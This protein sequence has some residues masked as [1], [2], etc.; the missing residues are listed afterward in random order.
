MRKLF[1]Y[2]KEF[3]INDFVLLKYLSVALFLASCIALNYHFDFEDSIIDSYDGR[4][5]HF[6]FYF[7]FYAFAY[8]GTVAIISFFSTKSFLKEREF[9]IKSLFIIAVIALDASFYFHKYLLYGLPWD[10]FYTLQKILRNLINIIT[11]LLP[12][13]A[14]Y[15]F[16]EKRNKTFYGVTK[17]EFDSRPYFIIL[18]I[19]LPVIVIASFHDNFSAFYPMYKTNTAHAYFNVPESLPALIYELAYGWNFFTVEL[20]FRGF[21]ILSLIAIMG[22]NSVLPM[23]ALYCFYHFGKPS[24]EAISSILGGYVLGVIAFKTRSI[25]GGVIVH[26]GIA[27]MM[28]FFAWLQKSNQ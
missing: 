27:W 4:P 22:T 18:L 10:V 14:F 1:Q 19:M 16:Y 20:V 13:T 23:V 8:Y 17:V 25:L 9:W 11:T 7:L 5:I 26:I 24:G 2:L 28:E 12:I 6:L 21:L 3:F 15:W